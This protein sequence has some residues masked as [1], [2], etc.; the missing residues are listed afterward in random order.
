MGRRSSMRPVIGRALAALKLVSRPDIAARLICDGNFFWPYKND[1]SALNNTEFAIDIYRRSQ[2]PVG[3]IAAQIARGGRDFLFSRYDEIKVT[4]GEEEALLSRTGR[5]VSHC[6]LLIGLGSYAWL[7]GDFVE[8]RQCFARAGRLMQA[9]GDLVRGSVCLLNL[10]EAEFARGDTE[11]AIR[12]SY[13]SIAGIRSIG[14]PPRLG[15]ALNNLT[16]YL[17]H[18]GRQEEARACACEALGIARAEPGTGIGR[19][20]LQR[21]ALLAALDGGYAEAARL[22]GFVQADLAAAA[23]WRTWTEEYVHKAISLLLSANLPSAEATALAVEGAGWSEA[24]AVAFI[25]RHFVSS[26][27]SP[28]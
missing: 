20:C 19:D 6:R 9:L 5:R 7:V 8:A 16:A 13:Q 15:V 28:P 18:D 11:S 22:N 12:T 23:Q 26:A 27:E 14:R 25:L 3:L 4:L 2:N 10:A 1:E 24:E 21:W 17:L